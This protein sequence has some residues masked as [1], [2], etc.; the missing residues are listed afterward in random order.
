LI[1]KPQY[2]GIISYKRR[3]TEQDEMQAWIDLRTNGMLKGPMSAG[4]DWKRNWDR[5][6]QTPWLYNSQ[7]DVFITYEDPKSLKAK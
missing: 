3:L 7:T 6:S 1:P 4:Q 5:D 2:N